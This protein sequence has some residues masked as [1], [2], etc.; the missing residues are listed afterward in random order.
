MPNIFNRTSRNVDKIN[1]E[2]KFIAPLGLGLESRTR[3]SLHNIA[4]LS[5]F[6][7]GTITTTKR[8]F[9]MPLG[10]AINIGNEPSTGLI[11]SVASTN[12]NDTSAGTG[13][14]QITIQGLDINW[15]PLTESGI[16]LNG[17]TP[18]STTNE[19]YRL[20][21]IWVDDVGSNTKNF[22]DIYISDT[23]DTFI[24]GIPQNRV[25]IAMIAGENNSTYGTISFG[26]HKEAFLTTA[27]LYT[28]ATPN[29][30]VIIQERYTG[31]NFTGGNTE[32]RT[33]YSS[34]PLWFTGNVGYDF[35][36][37]GQY[38]EKTTINW[39]VSSSTGTN[40]GT[41]YYTFSV[42]DIAKRSHV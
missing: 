9:G 40:E 31:L 10:S 20:N 7:A 15:E 39:I 37:F 34:G 4:P 1:G 12:A 3:T 18:V 25:Y 11:L 16:L 26:A 32:G 13:A 27:T 30:P 41:F 17:Q 6:A 42:N 28:N 22:G 14:Q 24:G 35:T 19:F 21:K 8:T 23:S 2:S 5:L 29:N 38:T 36:G 33:S